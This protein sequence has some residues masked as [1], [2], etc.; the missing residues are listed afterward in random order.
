MP[1]FENKTAPFIQSG[2]ISFL[3]EKT[4]NVVFQPSF[5]DIPSVDLTLGDETLTPPYRINVTKNGF[6]IKFKIS[7]TGEVEWKAIDPQIN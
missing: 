6:T 5:S 2:T 1:I 3:N 7:Y 4:K